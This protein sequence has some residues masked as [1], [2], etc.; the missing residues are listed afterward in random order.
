MT[1]EAERKLALDRLR[2]ICD[3]KLISVYDFHTN[4]SRIYSAHEVGM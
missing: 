2:K 3:N 4:P 1:L